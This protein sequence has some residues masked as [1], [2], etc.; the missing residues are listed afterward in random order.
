M[1]PAPSRMASAATRRLAVAAALALGCGA[2]ATAQMPRPAPKNPT[3][4]ETIK[5][6]DLELDSVRAEQ[7]RATEA[8]QKLVIESDSLSEERRRLNQSLIEN[9]AGVRAHE[10]QIAAAEIHLRQLE[11]SE[12]DIHKSLEDRRT[13]IAEVLAALQRIGHRPP[14][15]VFVGAEDAIES[16]RTAISLGAVTLPE[17]RG[18]ATR[19]SVELADLARARKKG[20]RGAQPSGRPALPNSIP[21]RPAWRL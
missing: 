14:P 21:R 2:V 16:V 9:A 20:K 17:M 19:L 10:E 1:A 11:A 15:A 18:E 5:Q 7:R 4:V 6:R 12:A 8:E 13:V 3:A